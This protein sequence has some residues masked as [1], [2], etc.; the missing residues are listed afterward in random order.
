[1]RSPLLFAVT[2]SLLL[3]GCTATGT[4]GVSYSAEVSVPA[5]VYIDSDVR[6][7]ADYDEPIFY[8]DSFYWRQSG[9]VW[10]RSPQYRSGWI[11]YAA[12]PSIRRIERPSAYVRYRA[13]TRS[14]PVGRNNSAARSNQRT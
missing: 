5:M 4:T 10:Y 6:V 13:S 3:I 7:I 12:P 2:S 11:V 8:T 1:M 14:R 9:G